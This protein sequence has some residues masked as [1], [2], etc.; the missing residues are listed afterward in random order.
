MRL[1]HLRPLD[2]R[3]RGRRRAEHATFGRLA[4]GHQRRQMGQDRR[5]VVQLDRLVHADAELVR[6]LLDRG[7][8]VQPS[9]DIVAG[10][11]V[12]LH[13]RPQPLREEI[14]PAELVEDRSLNP[15][16]GVRGELESLRRIPAL[17]RVDEPEAA[18]GVELLERFHRACP[19]GESTGHDRDQRR[20]VG[21]Q[22]VPKF[23]GSVLPILLP[24]CLRCCCSCSIV[25]T[26]DS[27]LLESI[28]PTS[29]IK[30]PPIARHCSANERSPPRAIS[31]TP[32]E[33][34]GNTVTSGR[35]S[36]LVAS[37]RSAHPPEFP[38]AH[39]T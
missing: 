28:G 10:D 35:Q 17:D 8:P 34:E 11:V 22:A 26:L 3:G 12:D 38:R 25:C 14:L 1:C 30:P 37:I 2:R 9:G 33:T 4:P 13:P 29:V 19:P 27:P 20:V 16:G 24:E 5:V 32:R 18:E 36:R 6:H 39:V 21:H 23:N 15:S 7:R 31:G